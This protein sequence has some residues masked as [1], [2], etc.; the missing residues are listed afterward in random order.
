MIFESYLFQSIPCIQRYYQLDG[1]GDLDQGRFRKRAVFNRSLRLLRLKADPSC[2][3]ACLLIMYQ[4]YKKTQRC[5]LRKKCK[6]PQKPGSCESFD[7]DPF[8]PSNSSEIFFLY[9]LVEGDGFVIDV[10]VNKRRFSQRILVWCYRRQKLEMQNLC[11]FFNREKLA[12]IWI[13]FSATRPFNSSISNR[14]PNRPT[15]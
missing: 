12:N 13:R 14:S 11:Q 1:R 4:Q 5:L 9:L 10:W 6:I 15:H 8:L 2:I 7:D 3:A